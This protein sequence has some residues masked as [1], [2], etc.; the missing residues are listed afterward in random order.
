MFG[1]NTVFAR[2][3]DPKAGVSETKRHKSGT[4]APPHSE[5]A[6]ARRVPLRGTLVALIAIAGLG[7]AIYQVPRVRSFAIEGNAATPDDAIVAASGVALGQHV[8]ETDLDAVKVNLER[9]PR[10]RN[11][12]VHFRL[13]STLAIAIHESESDARLSKNNEDIVIDRDGLVIYIGQAEGKREIPQVLGMSISGYKEGAQLGISDEYQFWAMKQ[14]IH[15]LYDSGH[16]NEYALID[17]SDPVD[18]KMMNYER[19]TVH[20]GQ[21]DGLEQKLTRAKPVLDELKEQGLSG[22]VLDV[23]T[24]QTAYRPAGENEIFVPEEWNQWLPPALGAQAV[25]AYEDPSSAAPAVEIEPEFPSDEGPPP[26]E[27]TVGETIQAPNEGETPPDT[28]TA[29]TPKPAPKPKPKSK[30]TVDPADAFG[31]PEE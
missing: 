19:I 20:F 31:I 22:G 3:H 30:A 26:L 23:S 27:V 8:F 11:V 25:A 7:M 16:A 4:G 13:P 9:N 17:L 24:D 21:L 14:T 18:I 12:E 2:R 5:D 6:P 15:L 10:F 28:G 1:Q 29:T